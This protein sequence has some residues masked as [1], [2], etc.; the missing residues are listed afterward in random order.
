MGD[1]DTC[2]AVAG[3]LST[4]F[5]AFVGEWDR[6]EKKKENGWRYLRARVDRNGRG[7]CVGWGLLALGRRGSRANLRRW[8][9]WIQD[10][11]IIRDDDDDDEL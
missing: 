7:Q 9:F 2:R 3:F 11:C 6:P 10:C 1:D 8:E 4:G 5:G